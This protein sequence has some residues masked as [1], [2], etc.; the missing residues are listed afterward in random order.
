[1]L[2]GI[3][4]KQTDTFSLQ[5]AF[6][7]NSLQDISYLKAQISWGAVYGFEYEMFTFEEIGKVLSEDY[8]FSPFK[9]KLK[10]EGAV[11]NKEKHPNAFGRIRGKANV[12]NSITWICLDIDNTTISDK[13]MQL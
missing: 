6:S 3:S 13:A 4:F 12:N 11:Y 2:H 1:M 8:A 9:Y 7:N 10:E 5:T